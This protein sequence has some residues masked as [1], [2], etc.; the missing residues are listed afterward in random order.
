MGRRRS[1]SLSPS[2]LDS[3]AALLAW[4]LRCNSA[5]RSDTALP[6][7]APKNAYPVQPT[8]GRRQARSRRP[9]LLA[10]AGTG[11]VALIRPGLACWRAAALTTADRQ[12]APLARGP[13]GRVPGL[14]CAVRA[15][16]AAGV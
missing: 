12:A 4:S 9:A 16:R 7:L 10:A 3:N 13:A 2:S 5:F 14:K 6:R 11:R 8:T 15:R 1:Y